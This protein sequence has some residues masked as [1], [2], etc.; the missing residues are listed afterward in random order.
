MESCSDAGALCRLDVRL[1]A[2]LRGALVAGAPE[3]RLE[4]DDPVVTLSFGSKK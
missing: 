1:L 4:D 3:L 2:D